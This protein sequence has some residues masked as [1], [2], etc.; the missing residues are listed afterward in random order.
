MSNKTLATL[1]ST[2]RLKIVFGYDIFMSLRSIWENLWLPQMEMM[3]LP[4][5]NRKNW[6]IIRAFVRLCLRPT[7]Q[8]TFQC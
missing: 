5:K 7:E 3:T 1:D 6:V 2:G 4:L 8:F